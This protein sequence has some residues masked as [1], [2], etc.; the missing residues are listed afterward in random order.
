VRTI[1]TPTG[2]QVVSVETIS[3]MPATL[4]IR[5]LALRPETGANLTLEQSFQWVE[6]M[7]GRTSNWGPYEIDADRYQRFIARKADLDSGAISYRAIGALTK[8]GAISNCGQSFARSS[9]IV[10][11]RYLQ[12]T[13]SPGENGTSKLA[14]RYLKAGALANNAATN[15]GVFQA[16]GGNL[17]PSTPRAPGERIPNRR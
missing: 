7:G 4:A 8:N 16:E 6:S 1:V 3:W 12:P 13:P 14:L 11:N 10:G 5:P 9:P 2:E 15:E 17:Y